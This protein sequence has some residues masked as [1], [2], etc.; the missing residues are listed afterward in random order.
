MI[1]LRLYNTKP[2]MILID[3]RDINTIP[4]KANIAFGTGGEDMDAITCAN[5]VACIHETIVSFPD[6]Y[7]T[8]VGERGSTLSGWQKQP[9]SG[10][11]FDIHAS[12]CYGICFYCSSNSF[13]SKSLRLR[14]RIV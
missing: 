13:S 14:I 4:L 1:F 11:F 6:G 12:F 9:L 2:G 8:I 5:S 3:G 7:E 10:C